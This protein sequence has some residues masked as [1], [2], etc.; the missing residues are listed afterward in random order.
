MKSGPVSPRDAN[1]LGCRGC[2]GLGSRVG[3]VDY[4]VNWGVVVKRPALRHLA[5]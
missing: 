2:L 5:C 1:A 4:S 3:L